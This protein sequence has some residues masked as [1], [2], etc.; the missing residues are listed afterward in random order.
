MT[1]N[2]ILILAKI[3][4]YASG[5]RTVTIT[6]LEKKIAAE[7]LKRMADQRMDWTMK[8]KEQYKILVDVVER[9]G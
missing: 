8:E 5:N 6:D 1:I 7:A 2:E 4:A 9:I 3:L